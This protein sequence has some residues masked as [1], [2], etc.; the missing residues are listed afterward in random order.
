MEPALL[1]LER[2]IAAPAERCFRAF[3]DLKQLRHWVP[4]VRRVK[5]VREREDGLP[6]EAIVDHGSTLSYSM[7]YAYDLAARRVEWE[8][9]VG[10]RDAVRG[11]AEFVDEGG[12][13]LMRYAVAG[14]RD[15]AEAE[16]V[17]EAFA[18]WVEA[19]PR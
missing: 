13:C 9:G 18:R 3:C 1:P 16:T 10:R 7:M 6:L 15:A 5:V 4:G 17:V 11:W 19:G 14:N 12:A 2:R 8:P